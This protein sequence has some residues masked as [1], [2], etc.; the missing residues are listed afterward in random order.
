MESETLN[1]VGRD[2]L[3]VGWLNGFFVRG[4]ARAE[5]A[6]VTPTQAQISPIL[7]KCEE[8]RVQQVEQ[9]QNPYLILATFR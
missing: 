8:A 6:Q 1:G 7:I 3:R 2:R 5:D 4:T 9:V